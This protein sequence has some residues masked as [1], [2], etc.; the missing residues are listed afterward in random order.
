[1]R[2]YYGRAQVMPALSGGIDTAQS[3]GTAGKGLRTTGVLLVQSVALEM[4]LLFRA[5]SPVHPAK[6]RP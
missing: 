6:R 2:Q 3:F 4:A 5:S 1:M